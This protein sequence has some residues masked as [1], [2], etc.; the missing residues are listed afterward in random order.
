MRSNLLT[1]ERRLEEILKR[2]SLLRGCRPC[3]NVAGT[4][5]SLDPRRVGLQIVFVLIF[6]FLFWRIPCRV[7]L[8]I[9]FLY[10]VFD[11]LMNPSS[12]RS[13]NCNFVFCIWY[14]EEYH[15]RLTHSFMWEFVKCPQP[16]ALI[17]DLFVWLAFTHIRID[18]PGNVLLVSFS[19]N[20]A[21]L[22]SKR[23][24]CAWKIYFQRARVHWEWPKCR[25]IA[26][27][28]EPIE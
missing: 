28:C 17:R 2:S 15:Y 9:V 27:N 19:G 23:S 8:Q 3:G 20:F 16:F 24:T 11:I 10:F 26:P 13:A 4:Q 1:W 5:R 7:G 25:W 12:G 22:F 6:Y 21:C 18:C 14:F